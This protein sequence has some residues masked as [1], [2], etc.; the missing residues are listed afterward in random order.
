MRGKCEWSLHCALD[1]STSKIRKPTGQHAFDRECA[2]FKIEH[3]LI[4]P[5]NPQTNGMVERFN[6][7]I[8]DILAATR[9]LSRDGLQTTIKCYAELLQR[10]PG[11]ERLRPQDT[12]QAIRMWRKLET[13]FIR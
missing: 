12:L 8:S 10:I 7:R 1:R 9:F 3:R 2:I 4:K 11:A 13:K 5:R 6:G